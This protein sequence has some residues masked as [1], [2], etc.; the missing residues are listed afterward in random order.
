MNKIRTRFAP[1]PTGY[2]HIGNFR[3]ALYGYLFAKKN[4]GDFILRIEDTDQKREVADALE[5]LIAIINWASFEYC[6]GVY[7]E[8]GKIIEK[9]NFGPYTQSKRLEIYKK[10]A[11]QLVEIGK[12]YYCFCTPERLEEMRQNQL[13]QKQA[14]MYDQCCLKL[15]SEEIKKRLDSGEKYVIR[16][17]INTQGSTIFND[18]IRGKVEIKNDLLDDQIIL[19][20]DGYPTY[21]FANVI[22]DHLMEISHIFRGEEYVSSTPK[23]IQLYESFG[24]QVPEVAHLPLLL[25]PDKSKLS[26]RQGDVAV[27]DYIKKGYL[28][29]AI[30]N[31]VAMLGWNPGEG[32]TQ[33]IFTLSELVEKFDLAHVHKA[34]AVFDIKKLDWINSQW[35]KKLSLEELY[36]KSLEFFEEKEFYKNAS[37]EKKSEEYI[38]KILFIE[39][40]RLANLSEVGESN[41]FFF[42]DINFDKELLRWKDMSDDDLKKSLKKSLSVL[43]NIIDENWT[44]ENLE[45][46]L[47]ESAGENRGELLWPLRA[48]LT[49]EKK[50]PSPFECAWVLGKEESLKRIKQALGKI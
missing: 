15:S 41:Q 38:K 42:R 43:E 49:G 36:E 45:K 24:W 11:L 30:I 8:N 9:G 18:L 25:N 48:T 20:S 2:M 5:K 13:A 26:K 16:Q 32:S 3:T 23:Y 10:Y 21:N 17:K 7:L 40:D 19:K 6:E 28:K 50:S 31:F 47:M 37:E 27:E 1:S 12:A 44:R 4:N 46:I 34:G 14:P 29:E 39:K 22:D 35:I 33:E